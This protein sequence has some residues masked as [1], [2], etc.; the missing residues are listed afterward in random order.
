MP[1]GRDQA[2]ADL[3]HRAP[4]DRGWRVSYRRGRMADRVVWIRSVGVVSAL[5]DDWPTTATALA[6]GACGIAPIE[7]FDATGMPCTVASVVPR[8]CDG[9]RRIQLARIAMREAWP[10]GGAGGTIGVFVGAESGLGSWQAVWEL[11]R[12]GA[13]HDR[14]AFAAQRDAAVTWADP[15]R[16]SAPAVAWAIAREVG[17]TGPCRT[18]ALA[19]A[20]GIAA[21]IEASRALAAG[22]CDT[23]VCVGVGADVDPLVAAAFGRLGAL[24]TRGRSSPFDVARDGFVLGEGAAAIVLSVERGDATVALAG[25]ARTFD[26]GSLT[27]PDPHADGARRALAA[28]LADAGTAD[29]GY[30]AAHGTS[31]PAGDAAEAAALRAVLGD[32]A[33][34]GAVK[35]AL[36]HWIAGA[37]TLGAVCAWH[38]IARGE[39]LPTVGVDRVADD[40]ALPHVLGEAVRARVDAA[41]A[42][43]FGFGG[44]NACVVMRR[45]A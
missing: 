35:G 5:G 26:G 34:V 12:A 11:A 19:C 7:R 2:R 9:D 45:A 14:R 22:A 29:I 30:V 28:A 36:G 8:P 10:R 32:R 25:G 33:R 16:T 27:A 44:A 37:G 43:A 39:L 1:V 4:V 18:V 38:A 17:A 20:S 42:C 3:F 21:L 24:S 23:A 31:T 41:A 6:R 15:E 13:T 40:C